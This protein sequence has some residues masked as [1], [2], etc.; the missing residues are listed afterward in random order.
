MMLITSLEPVSKTRTR[1]TFDYDRTLVLSD[2]D[3]A[4]Y[5][6]QQDREIDDSVYEGIVKEQRS[7]ALVRAGN[8]LKG[9]DYTRRGLHD[10]LLRAGYPEEIAADVVDRLLDAGY[11]NDRRYAESYVRQHIGDRSLARIQMDLRNKGIDKDFLA[12]IL[13]SYEEENV[14]DLAEQELTQI[15]KI[16]QRRHYDPETMSYEEIARIKAAILRKGYSMERIRKAMHT[17]N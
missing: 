2:R 17:I 11:I 12:E 13:Q 9:M 8:L 15:R 10:R 16:L 1:V 7:A 3:M 6:I 5:G 4:I 14:G